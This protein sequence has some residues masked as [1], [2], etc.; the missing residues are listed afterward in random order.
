MRHFS[1]QSGFTLIEIMVSLALLGVAVMVLL[2]T[3]Y[4]AMRLFTDTRDEVMM[5][6]LLNSA[7]G[8]AEV[9]VMA[10]S[11]GGAGQFGKRYEGYSFTYA[12]QPFGTLATVP[13]Y[14]VTVTVTGPEESRTMMM[15][16]YNIG[17]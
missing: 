1:R 7:L 2:E 17:Q 12:A 3:H 14:N 9:Q 6:G 16:I 4:G 8:Q 10:G 5:A 15:M 13:L 11:L